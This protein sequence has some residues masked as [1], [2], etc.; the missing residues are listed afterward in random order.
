MLN[1]SKSSFLFSAVLKN[2]SKERKYHQ[3]KHFRLE[4]LFCTKIT[5]IRKN[6]MQKHK[7]IL[8]LH[9]FYHTDAHILFASVYSYYF[10][11]YF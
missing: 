9:Y 8:H 5:N 10:K 3:Q 7:N 11:E 2:T 4:K 6:L 1:N